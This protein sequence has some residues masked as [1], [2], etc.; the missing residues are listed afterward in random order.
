M[1]RVFRILALVVLVFSIP[2]QSVSADG[3]APVVP[4]D[5][6]PTRQTNGPVNETPSLWFVELASPPAIEGSSQPALENDQAQFQVQAAQAGLEFEPRLSFSTLWNGISISIQPS[7]LNKL[8]RIPAVKAIYPIQTIPIPPSVAL[9]K[10]ELATALLMTG[11]DIVQNELGFTGKGIKVGVIDTGIDFDHPDLGGC[12]GPGCRVAVGHDF[13]GDA[14]DP[15]PFSPTF[16]PTPVP[17]DNPDDCNGHGTHVSGIIGAN[18]KVKGVAPE[19]TFGAYR[20]FGCSGSTTDDILLKAMERAQADGMQV[21]NMSL[22]SA[23][24]WPQ[25][26]TA[27]AANRLVD[28]GIVVVAAAGN[29][30][31]FGVYSAG[32]PGLAEKVIGVASYDN[33]HVS[34][35]VFQANPDEREIPYLP[36]DGGPEVPT[37]GTTPEL[38]FVGQGCAQDDYLADPDGKVA[39]I[40]RG[41]CTFDE[42]YLKAVQNGAKGVII[43]N[44]VPG[45]FSGGGLIDRQSFAVGITQEDGEYLRDQIANQKDGVTITWTNKLGKAPLPTGGLISSFSSY[46]LAPDLSLKPDLGAPGGY[47]R[48]TVPLEQ[49]GYAVFS[50]TSMASPHVAGAAALLLQAKPNTPAAAVLGIFQNNAVP[51][52]WSGDTSLN[53]LEPVNHQGAGMLRIDAAIQATTRI[54]PSKLAVGESQAG[55]RTFTLTVINTANHAVLYDLLFANALS[56][57]GLMTPDFWSSD[58]SVTFD[59]PNLNISAH[60]AARLKVTIHPATEPEMSQYGGYI[61]FKP[62]LGGQTYRVPYAGFVGDYQAIKVLEPTANGFPWLAKLTGSF[63]SNQPNGAAFSMVAGDTPYIV[64]HFEHQASHVALD[65]L[66]AKTGKVWHR[67][68]SEAY[69]PRNA[70]E[71]GFYTIPWDGLA[72]VDGSLVRVPDGQYKIRVHVLHALGDGK[73]PKDWDRWVSPIITISWTRGPL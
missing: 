11:A 22:G 42:K 34:A 55:P 45:I 69:F 16:N 63:L 13:V 29:E 25:Y 8:R 50:G 71:D 19:V 18:G 68:F 30:G 57:G 49:G 54:S 2:L 58:A 24:Q 4:R 35:I 60:S 33:T 62:R 70:T 21:I 43:Y 64:L 41:A 39:L 7:E 46:G 61:I 28:H 15:D 56:T 36:L 27:R 48:S 40:I 10:P 67:I 14:F 6:P 1:L 17:D 44:N 65:V 52:L 12:F 5:P 37:K 51:K 73:N 32:A 47:I 53:I 23:F 59:Q 9:T 38:V 66:D 72:E 26:P 20:V 3:A 31:D